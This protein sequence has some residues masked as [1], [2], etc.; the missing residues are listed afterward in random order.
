M[1]KDVELIN[2]ENYTIMIKI[3]R[4]KKAPLPIYFSFFSYEIFGFSTFN[5]YPFPQSLPTDRCNCLNLNSSRRYV[6]FLNSQLIEEL[7]R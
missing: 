3:W 5:F 4:V 2:E 1:L 6:V 7:E